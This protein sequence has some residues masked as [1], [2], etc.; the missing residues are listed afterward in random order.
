MKIEK[1]IL[2]CDNSYYK[3]YWP[4]VAKVCKKQLGVTPVLFKIGNTET[5][6]YFDGNGLVKQVKAI[7]NVQ[8]NIQSI[9]YRLYGTKFFP[10][11]VCLI[12]DIDMML[13]SYDYFQNTIKDFDED[14]IVVYSSDAYDLQRNDSKGWFDSNIFA[15]CYNAAKG[16]IFE[17]IFN[18]EGSFSD[19]FDRLSKFKYEKILKWYGDEIY[20]T[21]KIEE[22]SDRF[23][24]HKLRRG[25]EE[26]FFLK[27]RIEKWHF[28]IDYVDNQMKLLNARDGSYDEKLLKEGFYLDCHCVRP[29]DLYEKEINYVADIITCREKL[30]QTIPGQDYSTVNDRCL[31]H[32][33]DVVDIG[34]LNW[35][36]SNFFIGK[37]RVIGV[38]PFENQIKHTE[39]FK[40][41]IGKEDGII[42]IK[43][44]GINTSMINSEGGEEV[45]VKTWKNF[46]KEF[47]IN[48]ISLLKINIEGAE[49]D[50]LDSFDNQDFENIDQIAI[51][52]HDW[53]IPEWKSK[54]EKSLSIL[55]SKN[56]SLQK[57]NNSWNW[58]LA[59]K[60]EFLNE[61]YQD[62]KKMKNY[63]FTE[64][65]FESDDLNKFTAKGTQKELHI[66]EIGS[67]EGKST[68]WF[69]ENLLQNQNSSITCIDS[70]TSY[71]QNNDSFRSYNSENTE[72]DFKNHKN[73]FLYNIKE[74]GFE[75]KV[76]IIQ[77]FSHEILP[78]LINKN[79]FDIIFIDGNH[80]AP[81]VITDAVFSW[82]M[83]K[84]N[85][86]LIFDDYQWGKSENLIGTTLTPKLAIDSF[87]DCFSD[88]LEVIHKE[89][90]LAIRKIK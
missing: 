52:F 25:Y 30:I 44:E 40:G 46:C 5:D 68:V 83:L 23:Q 90:R 43:N 7:P 36:W 57:I 51:S 87:V 67:F 88:Y 12:S 89:W 80:T 50:L 77:G 15:M 17:E 26:G 62:K 3:D 81:F 75:N 47:S 78:E 1:L 42:K 55:E 69:L 61:K 20:L 53:M 66:L 6:F 11:E 76:N 2:S 64:N 21:K 8:I 33:G 59:T 29:F 49:Y 27:D 34:C 60:K 31:I 86:L 24:V 73:T 38:D 82:Y 37:K 19:F 28:P 32:N 71:S 45:K 58:F 72:W 74:S 9:F 63:K 54:T 13:F 41:V 10:D 4:V 16:K 35:D 22:F 70:W 84:T 65:W 56:F 39:L 85:G 79:K 18:L 14:S 48:K